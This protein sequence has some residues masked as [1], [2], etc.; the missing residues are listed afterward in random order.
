MGQTAP[1]RTPMHDAQGNLT[2]PWVLYFAG[3]GGSGGGSAAGGAP[4]NLSI[5]GGGVTI[6]LAAGTKFV[7]TLTS[8]A[9]VTIGAPINSGG[10]V[11][12][13]QDFI[14]YIVQDATGGWPC[15]AFTGGAGGFAGDT[16]SRILSLPIG[17]NVTA[18][19][20]TSLSFSANTAVVWVIGNGSS[21][22]QLS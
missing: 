20:Q 15:P 13:G 7:L 14:L 4:T 9:S 2:R 16:Q 21:G 11:T 22:G 5:V 3:G 12:A 8:A 10:S 17:Y 19:T 1:I 18:D 6:D